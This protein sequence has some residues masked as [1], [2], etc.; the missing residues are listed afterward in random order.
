MTSSSSMG[1][2]GSMMG[3]SQM[4]SKM[5]M[6]NPSASFNSFPNSNPNYNLNPKPAAPM[7]PMNGNGPRPTTGSVHA[8]VRPT[9]GSMGTGWTLQNPMTRQGQ[10]NVM[11]PMVQNQSNNQTN[12]KRLTAADI[13]SLLG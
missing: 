12:A 6:I 1:N 3:S 9:T 2:F 4:N 7:M 10:P 11:Q 5:P 8:P 13:D